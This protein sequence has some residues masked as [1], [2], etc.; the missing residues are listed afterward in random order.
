[1]REDDAMTM[2]AVPIGD[3]VDDAGP[4]VEPPVGE[5]DPNIE[6]VESEADSTSD[7]DIDPIDGDADVVENW[8][9]YLTRERWLGEEPSFE[10]PL[11]PRLMVFGGLEIDYNGQAVVLAPGSW[12]AFTHGEITASDDE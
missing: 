5:T 8:F 7:D 9:V 3:P 4:L 11:R 6:V 2:R 1:M 12:Y 10:I